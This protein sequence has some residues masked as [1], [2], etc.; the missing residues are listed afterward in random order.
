MNTLQVV[1][2]KQPPLK[3][4]EPQEDGPMPWGDD[5][6]AVLNVQAGDPVAF[7]FL[8]EKYIARMKSVASRYVRSPQDAEDVVQE[9]FLKAYAAI[10]SF[11]P[12]IWPHFS[13]WLYRICINCAIDFRRKIYRSPA[14]MPVSIEELL[15]DPPEPGP[16]PEDLA[17]A[18]QAWGGLTKA[19]ADLPPR[20]RMIFDLRYRERLEVKE[21]A[22]RLGCS[23]CNIRLHLARS[24]TK[25]RTLIQLVPSAS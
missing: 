19:T 21:I 13:A 1:L 3:N 10:D 2:T 23:E 11:N 16:S 14:Q 20:Q 4:P 25:L 6:Q 7:Q 15:S 18:S 17:V 9:A 12:A 22:A 24:T 8:F 5:V